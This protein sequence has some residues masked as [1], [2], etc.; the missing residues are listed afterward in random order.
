MYVYSVQ[1]ISDIRICKNCDGS[2]SDPIIPLLEC[3]LFKIFFKLYPKLKKCWLF[4]S[5]TNANSFKLIRKTYNFQINK[6]HIS[7]VKLQFISSLLDPREIFFIRH[8]LKMDQLLH[9]LGVN[10]SWNA[11]DIASK[12]NKSS[13]KIQAA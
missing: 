6:L 13:M 5:C 7:L 10:K 12:H 4:L 11:N 8:M 2:Q 1:R 9:H 3:K